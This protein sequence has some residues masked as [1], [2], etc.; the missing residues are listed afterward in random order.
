MSQDRI[1]DL[2]QQQL[3]QYIVDQSIA[4]T[5]ASG[6]DMPREVG[7]NF[8]YEMEAPDSYRFDVLE[9]VFQCVSF[10][11]VQQRNDS[12]VITALKEIIYEISDI[13]GAQQAQ[14]SEYISQ[15]AKVTS[16][17]FLAP[18]VISSMH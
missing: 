5:Q 14:V 1:E 13:S 8:L 2:T 15:I 4:V 12:E 9:S 7:E 17:G 16:E 10:C 11:V 6:F 18:L 3:D